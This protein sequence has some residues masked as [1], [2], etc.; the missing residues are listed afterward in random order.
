[1]ANCGVEHSHTID[2]C[3]RLGLC[4]EKLSR[5]EEAFS[6]YQDMVY[7]LGGVV[8]EEHPATQKVHGWIIRLEDILA[9]QR[10]NM[11]DGGEESGSGEE[12]NSGG[13]ESD[14]G[15]ESAEDAQLDAALGFNDVANVEGGKSKVVY[16]DE[17]Q[18]EE[19]M[20]SL[21]DFQKMQGDANSHY[22]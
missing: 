20:E 17:G 10:E 5:Y 6:L 11:S 13:E 3:A 18:E 15:E 14:N 9:N 1:M 22:E 19:W 16:E 7:Q 21:F 2:A 8:G 4:Y 12:P